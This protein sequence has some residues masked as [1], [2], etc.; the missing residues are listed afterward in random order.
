MGCTMQP[1]CFK[2]WKSALLVGNSCSPKLSSTF[3]VFLNP[4]HSSPFPTHPGPPKGPVTK[5]RAAKLW[6][7]VVLVG[8]KAASK[9]ERYLSMVTKMA[10]GM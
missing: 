8:C 10:N 3:L 1:E 6:A 5:R 7:D 4:G 9:G 2:D